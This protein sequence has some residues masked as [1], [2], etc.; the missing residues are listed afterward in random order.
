MAFENACCFT[1]HRTVGNDLDNKRLDFVIRKLI[2]RGVDTFICGGALGFDTI[3]EQKIL[4]LKKEFS[5][6]KLHMYL[7]CNNQTSK[8]SFMQKMTYN[9]ILSHADYV[10]MPDKPYFDG[11]MKIR[12][13]KMVDNSAYCIAYYNGSYSSGTGQTLRY[14]EKKGLKLIN[15]RKSEKNNG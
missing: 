13:F 7:P 11:C 6:I 12:N 8:W 1:G 14:A 2:E 15:T 5:Q 10:D 4:E 9:K 3:V